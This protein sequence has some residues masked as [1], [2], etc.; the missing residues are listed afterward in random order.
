MHCLDAASVTFLKEHNFLF[1]FNSFGVV[2]LTYLFAGLE[3]YRSGFKPL[4][5]IIF[6]SIQRME[7]VLLIIKFTA[8]LYSILILKFET[9]FSCMFF[10]LRLP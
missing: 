9:S 1:L 6:L 10:L 5:K 2:Y 7:D 4:I 8:S 3:V